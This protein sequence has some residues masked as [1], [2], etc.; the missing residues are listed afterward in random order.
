MVAKGTVFGGVVGVGEVAT[1]EAV[2][3]P[4]VEV[5]AGGW[6]VGPEQAARTSIKLIAHLPFINRPNGRHRGR[7]TPSYRFSAR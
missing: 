6:L 1:G 5:W 3:E 2:R 4:E 7:V